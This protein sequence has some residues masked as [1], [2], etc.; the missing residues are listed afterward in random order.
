MS[1]VGVEGASFAVGAVLAFAGGV[2]SF[3]S[4]CVL[5]LV[6][7]Y[8]GH[9]AGAT[10]APGETPS[11]RAL[12]ANG[13][14][15]VF[16]FAAVFT[17]VGIGIGLFLTN[18]QAAQGWVRWIGGVAVILMGLHTTGL[19]RIPLLNRTLKAQMPK[20]VRPQPLAVGEMRGMGGGTATLAEPRTRNAEH[21]TRN[22]Q[23]PVLGRSFLVGVFFA[24]G[25]SPCVGPLLTGIFGVVSA[26]PASGGILL[27]IY[28]LGLGVPFLLIALLFG[29]ASGLLRR[30][31]RYYGAISLVSGAFLI[32]VGVLLLTDTLAR[33]SVYAPAIRIPGIT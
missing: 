21:G 2:L 4:P 17:V 33:L 15:F 22:F 24:A 10:V 6:P 29:R 1:S 8:I 32:L 3:V 5:P 31:N 18:V 23:L 30:V 25:W 19:V 28:S 16:G 11:R 20:A 9:L 27:F 7:G 14:A 12:L 13:L 26:Q